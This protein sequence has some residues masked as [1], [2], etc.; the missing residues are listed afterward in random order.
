MSLKIS[1]IIPTL[2]EE[3]TVAK[4]VKDFRKNRKVSEVIVFDGNSSD[5]TR[6]NA[7]K[8]GAKVLTQD[9]KGKGIAIREIFDRVDTDIYVLVDGDDTYPAES[10]DAL[11][12]PVLENKADMVVGTRINKMSQKGSLTRFHRFGNKFISS[13]LSLSF[14]QRLTDVLS[15]YRVI[16]RS[17]V[18]RT[19]ITS[20]GFEVETELSIKALLN[21]FRVL[22]VPI[23]YRKR[24]VKSESKLSSFSDG[25][26]IIYTIISML[27]DY[28]PLLFFSVLSLISG[29]IG[30]LTGISVVQ[31]WLATGLIT[32]IPTAIL[33]ALMIFL[34]VQFFTIG[35]VLDSIKR[36]LAEKK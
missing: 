1:V 23:K 34:S 9:G 10:L 17:V 30:L 3:A 4:V 22:E 16:K 29:A 32:R 36:M 24:S 35:I 28:K 20:K 14:G 27:R 13:L 26:L 21:N 7:R 8:A 25:Y 2:N 18:K 31:E 12:N 5:R 6:E 33:S 19:V 15:G 11:L